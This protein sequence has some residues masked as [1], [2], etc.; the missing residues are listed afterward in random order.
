MNDCWD[1]PLADP[2]NASGPS[3]NG[4]ANQRFTACSNAFGALGMDAGPTPNESIA[5]LNF[6]RDLPILQAYDDHLV[7]G[8]FGW[9]PTDTTGATVVEQPT[10]RVVVGPDP[11]NKPFLRFARCCFHHQAAFKVRSGGEWLTV[12]S[13]NGL[14]HHITTDPASGRCVP[15][16]DPNDALKNARTGRAVERRAR[17]RGAAERRRASID[18]NSPLAMRNPMFSYVMWSGCTRLVSN[19]HTETSRDMQWKFS[20]TGGFTPVTIALNG[21]SNIAVSPQSMRFI[22]SLGQLAIVDG[23][24]QGLVLIDLN[25]LGFAHNPYY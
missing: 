13:V 10:N 12:G 24:Q 20:I 8:R 25:T 9:Y 17:V 4:L 15:T 5:D 6:G 23:E 22:D 11:S 14:L 3:S 19:D 2:G 21:G 1:P 18:R 16:C 7:L